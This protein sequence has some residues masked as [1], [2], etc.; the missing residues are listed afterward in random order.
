V[1]DPHDLAELASLHPRPDIRLI[2]TDLDGTLL[3]DDKDINEEFWPLVDAL[4]ARGV[5]VAPASGRQYYTLAEQF[6]PIAHEAVFI[7]ENGTYV[8]DGRTSQ[9][10]SSDCLAT[11]AAHDVVRAVRDVP[12]A[13]AV[14][15]GKASAYVEQTEPGF[16]RE[17]EPYYRRLRVVDDLTTIADD[18]VLKVA[19][20]DAIWAEHNAGIA[21][22]H[23]RPALQVVVSGGH[24]VDVM[25]PTANK[26][27]AL[28]QVQQSLGATRDQTMVFGDFLN[29]LEMMD[30]AAYAFAM[31]NAHPRI[32]ERA[33]WIAPS[34]NANGVVRSIRAVLGLDE[35]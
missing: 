8:V 6:A 1:D 26:G 35:G 24:W 5:T 31:S 17:V 9:E 27:R 25:S 29:D 4:H 21:L 34:N 19:V 12:H 13:N 22:A 14:L 28:A 15:C 23:L 18:P 10:I 32:R 3:T 30:E 20:Y 11:A 2:A 33:S 16:M 7:A